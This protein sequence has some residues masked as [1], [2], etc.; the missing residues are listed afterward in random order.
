MDETEKT[1]IVSTPTS[2]PTGSET[3]DNYNAERVRQIN[4]LYDRNV[5]NIN[6]TYNAAYDRSRAELE[7]ARDKITPR[8]QD[9]MNQGAAEFERIRRNNDIRAASTGINSGAGSQLQLAASNAYQTGQAGLRR[10]ENEALAEADRG[11]A[12]L[13]TD[14]E[15][16]IAIA[17]GNNDFDRAKA[18]FDE[19]GDQY[20]RTLAQAEQRAG[21]GDF[22]MYAQLYGQSV[23]D[24]MKRDW[25]LRNPQI[26]YATGDL[27]AEDYFKLTGKY[28]PGYGGDTGYGSSGGRS[29]GGGTPQ[30]YYSSGTVA[31]VQ[32]AMGL[33]ADGIAGPDT[34]AALQSHPE[35]SQYLNK[36]YNT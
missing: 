29:Y 13:K 32:R 6:N 18:L 28:P 30:G 2:I 27:S 15:N 5:T 8:S 33:R 16:Q 7:A 3:L 1:S 36:W 23:A 35:Y 9:L 25:T 4:D 10:S 20:S 31:D 21:Y 24:Q 14:I 11:I 34:F 19:F 12:N 17:I 26:A 22:S